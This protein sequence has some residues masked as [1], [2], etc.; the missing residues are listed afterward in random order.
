MLI[1]CNKKPKLKT[2]NKLYVSS[3][4]RNLKQAIYFTVNILDLQRLREHKRLL[5]S[6]QPHIPRSLCCARRQLRKNLSF[7]H[8]VICPKEQIKIELRNFQLQ[9][10]STSGIWCQFKT[11]T[12]C[13]ISVFGDLKHSQCNIRPNPLKAF[14]DRIKWCKGQ[15]QVGSDKF[16][17]F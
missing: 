8:G 3:L 16:G 4:R 12:F 5:L 11:I 9:N 2:L 6:N 15:V 13:A 7:D 10:Q 1:I 17:Q 14:K